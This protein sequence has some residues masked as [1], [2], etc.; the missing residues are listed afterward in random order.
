MPDTTLHIAGIR[1]VLIAAVRGV[2][3]VEIDDLGD[4]S[5]LF[6]SASGC[7]QKWSSQISMMPQSLDLTNYEAESHEYIRI[8]AAAVKE[9]LA[10]RD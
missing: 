1:Q 5:Q 8:L 10:R 3:L 7:R 2:W 9:I 6:P 4:T